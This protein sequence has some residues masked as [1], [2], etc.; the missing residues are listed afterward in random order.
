MKIYLIAHQFDVDGGF[1]DAVQQEC[2]LFATPSKE[3]AN[4]YVERYNEPRIYDKPYDALYEHRLV[5]R[6]VTICTGLDD[7]PASW[8][9]DENP[10]WWEIAEQD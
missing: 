6:S 10:A 8:T 1:G 3:E 2:V 5:V 7:K 9:D 4:R